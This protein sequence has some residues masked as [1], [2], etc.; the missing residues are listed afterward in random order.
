MKSDSP[1]YGFVRGSNVQRDGMYLKLV[2][3]LS[4]DLVAEIFYSDENRS[5][6]RSN[7]LAD[8]YLL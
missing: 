5:V 4:R 6:I 3:E 1:G 7:S 2:D 8:H